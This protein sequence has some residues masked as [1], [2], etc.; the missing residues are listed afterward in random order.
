M[1]SL[2]FVYT[3]FLFCDDIKSCPNCF[4]TRSQ[5]G[6]RGPNGFEIHNALT[7]A[8]IT[9]SCLKGRPY[10]SLLSMASGRHYPTANLCRLKNLSPIFQKFKS[11]FC[12]DIFLRVPGSSHLTGC[13]L[14]PPTLWQM[15][16]L[17]TFLWLNSCKDRHLI[18]LPIL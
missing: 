7:L 18:S 2:L 9:L 14:N 10:F 13:T 15:R 1:L 5:S 6:P 11:Y 8:L 17:C 3:L 16:G 12:C 4:V